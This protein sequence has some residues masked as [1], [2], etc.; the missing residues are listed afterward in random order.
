MMLVVFVIVEYEISHFFTVIQFNSGNHKSP[1]F[2]VSGAFFWLGTFFGTNVSIFIS[3]KPQTMSVPDGC[4]KIKQFLTTRTYTADGLCRV[5][6]DSLRENQFSIGRRDVAIVVRRPWLHGESLP[7]APAI[8]SVML[9][10]PSD[11]I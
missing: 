2:S 4:H 10:R 8:M 1:T 11:H 9:S 6:L 7:A 3:N 5:L